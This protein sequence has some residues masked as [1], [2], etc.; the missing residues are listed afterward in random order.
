MFYPFFSEILCLILFQF[1]NYKMK[2][3]VSRIET[4]QSI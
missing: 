3:M 4:E 1:F 2:V